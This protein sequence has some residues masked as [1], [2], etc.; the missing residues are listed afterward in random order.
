MQPAKAQPA[1]YRELIAADDHCADACSR[2]QV[3]EGKWKVAPLPA[4]LMDRRV[5]ITGPTDRK[6][7]STDLVTGCAGMFRQLLTDRSYRVGALPSPY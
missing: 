6:M 7:V 2:L 3:R 4:D 1:T 5:E